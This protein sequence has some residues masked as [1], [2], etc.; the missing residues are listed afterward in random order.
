M[1]EDVDKYLR[2]D[3]FINK[4]ENELSRTRIKNLILNKNLRLNDKI[5]V[6]PA[7]KISTNDVLDLIIPEPK[8]ASLKPYDYKLHIIFEDEDIIVLD[9][10]AG[11]VDHPGAVNYDNTIVHDLLHYHKAYLSKIGV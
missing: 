4:K 8:N 7:K 6:D 11:I 10:P 2:V 5:I 1:V 9:K 3:V